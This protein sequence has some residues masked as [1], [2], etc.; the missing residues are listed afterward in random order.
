MPSLGLFAL[1]LYV[2]FHV[3][4]KALDILFG[5][6]GPVVTDLWRSLVFCVRKLD[7]PAAGK[8]IRFVCRSRDAEL[9]SEVYIAGSFNDWLQPKGAP[10][11]PYSSQRKA[12]RMRRVIEDGKAGWQKELWLSPGTYD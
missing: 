7:H 12:Y 5:L 1:L 3:V 10:I 9:A 6:F 11:R 8:P 4:D 2:S